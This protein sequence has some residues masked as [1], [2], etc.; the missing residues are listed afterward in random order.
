MIK[1][2][3]RNVRS[4]GKLVSVNIVAKEDDGY[5]TFS[6]KL[7][8]YSKGGA[9]FVVQDTNIKVGGQL[10]LEAFKGMQHDDKQI[11]T[12]V[13]WAVEVGGVTKFGCEFTFPEI[14]GLD[15]L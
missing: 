9:Q 14:G 15:L 4:D 7:I 5:R 6:A 8:N 3:R 12:I 13:V 11:S 10:F 2:K 1:E